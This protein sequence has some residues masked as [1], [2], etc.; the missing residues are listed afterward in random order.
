MPAFKIYMLNPRQIEVFRWT[1]SH[2]T[3]TAAAT[4]LGI[5][6]P[7]ASRMLSELEDACGFV[8][9]ER[10]GNQ[11]IPTPEAALFLSEVERYDTGLRALTR[12]AD[13]LRERGRGSLRVAAL[14]AMA[15]GYLPRLLARF[16][17]TRPLSSIHLHGMPSHLVMEAVGS[18]QADLGLAAAPVERQGLVIE[19][20]RARAVLAVPHAHRLAGRRRVRARDLTGERVIA[21][22]EPTIF[23]SRADRLLAGVD[24]RIVATTPLSGIACSMVACGAGVAVVD[25]FSVLDH[26]AQGVCAV[27]LE[28]PID[29]HIALVTAAHRRQ[30]ALVLEF[31][32]AL[33]EA[34]ATV[35]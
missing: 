13:D 6:Q 33:R 5:S 16:Q 4:E 32:D 20:L 21:L 24:C 8:L 25:P 18:G 15:M 11:L 22:T 2:G 27:R 10:R 35:G 34:A 12:F 23:G 29:V 28:P 19:P 3:A 14:P 7:A 9:F 26:L 31:I 1:M 17:A 30:S